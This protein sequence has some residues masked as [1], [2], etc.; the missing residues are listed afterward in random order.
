M[1]VFYSLRS[2]IVLFFLIIE[3]FYKIGVIFVKVEVI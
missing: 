3:R 1:K 2:F